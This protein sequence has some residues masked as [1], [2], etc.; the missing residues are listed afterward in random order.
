MRKETVRETDVNYL[1]PV[2]LDSITACNAYLVLYC[3]QCG[4]MKYE[5]GRIVSTW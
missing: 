3:G 2:A 5:W 4:K 1:Q